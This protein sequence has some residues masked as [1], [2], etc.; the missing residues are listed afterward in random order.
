[1][2]P[3][4]TAHDWGFDETDDCFDAAAGFAEGLEAEDDY[5]NSDGLCPWDDGWGED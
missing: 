2:G 5:W 1:M 4:D 3:E